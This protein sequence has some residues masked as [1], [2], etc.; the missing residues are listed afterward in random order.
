[1]LHLWLFQSLV[2]VWIPKY[3][4]LQWCKWPRGRWRNPDAERA[5]CS[6]R[7]PAQHCLLVSRSVAIQQLA[8]AGQQVCC[9]S[10]TFRSLD[11]P[12]VS[13]CVAVQQ[14]SDLLIF[15]WPAGVL[16]FSNFQIS[17]SSA[18]QQVCCCAATPELQA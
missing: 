7:W 17:L 13:K 8:S 11:L 1:M 2:W 12:L 9:C 4:A 3:H 6:C 14:L 5:R 10:A 18:G 15:R 16:L